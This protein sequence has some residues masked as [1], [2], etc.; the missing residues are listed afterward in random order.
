MTHVICFDHTTS[1]IACPLDLVRKT[2]AF[3]ALLRVGRI[4][5]SGKEFHP[6]EIGDCAQYNTYG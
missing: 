5:G 6:M 2:Q 4:V 3:Y 1:T